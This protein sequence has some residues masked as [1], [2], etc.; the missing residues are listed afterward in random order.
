PSELVHQ[1]TMR[2]VSLSLRL[3]RRIPRVVAFTGDIKRPHQLLYGDHSWS[4]FTHWR[5]GIAVRQFCAG[6]RITLASRDHGLFWKDCFGETP[7]PTRET[8]AL[9]GTG[10]DAQSLSNEL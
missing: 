7:K 3:R 2:L 8:H 9:P 1:E 10:K 6:C 4:P 5:R